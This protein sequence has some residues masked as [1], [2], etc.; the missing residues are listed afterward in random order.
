MTESYRIPNGT[1]IELTGA[2][3]T[4]IVVDQRGS[5]VLIT[6]PGGYTWVDRSTIVN[7]KVVR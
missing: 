1:M 5:R 4:G 6:A 2:S 7:R 3:W